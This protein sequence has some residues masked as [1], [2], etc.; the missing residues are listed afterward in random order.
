MANQIPPPTLKASV[1]EQ[2]PSLRLKSNSGQV[3]V[4]RLK[5]QRNEAAIQLSSWSTQVDVRYVE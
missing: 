4:I 3:P 1:L 5:I 2:F